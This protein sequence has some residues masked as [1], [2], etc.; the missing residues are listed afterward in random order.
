MANDFAARYGPWAL[1]TGASSGIGLELAR[2]A[3]ARGLNVAI[4]GRRADVLRGLA[5]ELQSR[6]SI[7]ARPLPIDLA[8]PTGASE[9]ITACA[10]LPL[11]LLI[12]SAGF[13]SGGSF[14]H[15]DAAGE[16]DMVEVNCRALLDL[17]HWAARR[18]AAQ[19]RGGIVLLSSLVSFQG[20]PHSPNYAATKAYVQSLA[21][22]IAP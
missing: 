8:S 14:L 21:E 20:V 3:A 6:H 17:T 2:L 12:N 1:V 7:E 11:G 15:A 13:G 18:F 9:L 19:R 16:R 10:D 4:T 5:E 22:G